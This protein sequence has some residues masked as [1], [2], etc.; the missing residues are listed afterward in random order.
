MMLCKELTF[1]TNSSACSAA[2]WANAPRSISSDRTPAL[3]TSVICKH[4]YGYGWNYFLNFMWKWFGKVERIHIKSETTIIRRLLDT[5]SKRF[6]LQI[7]AYFDL[8][9]QVRSFNTTLNIVLI[10]RSKIT[11]FNSYMKLCYH[12]PLK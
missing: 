10:T 1:L 11:K 9:S 6:P 5:F 2:L 3:S 12:H 7:C 4:Q 8:N